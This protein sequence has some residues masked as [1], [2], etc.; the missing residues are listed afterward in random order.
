MV[1]GISVVIFLG[2][3]GQPPGGVNINLVVEGAGVV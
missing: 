3:V 2:G 1:V